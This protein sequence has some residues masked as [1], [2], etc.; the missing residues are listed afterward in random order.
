MEA[1]PSL[2]SSQ[3]FLASMSWSISMKW[4]ARVSDS[5]VFARLG[6]E[7]GWLLQM[8]TRELQNG[9][10]GELT[11]AKQEGEDAKHEKQ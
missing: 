11:K 5:L 9:D 2:S 6:G 8:E 4:V 10:E 1:N 7:G 3:L